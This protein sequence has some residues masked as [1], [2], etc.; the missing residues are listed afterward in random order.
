MNM[1]LLISVCLTAGQWM[2]YWVLIF[3]QVQE[4]RTG[5]HWLFQQKGE[6]SGHVWECICPLDYIFIGWLRETHIFWTKAKK[7]AVSTE[8]V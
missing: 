7:T 4:N 8:T 6:T 2:D 1:H 5:K 3:Y